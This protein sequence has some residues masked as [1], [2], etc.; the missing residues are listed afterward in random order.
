MARLTIQGEAGSALAALEKLSALIAQANASTSS[1]VAAS[2][3]LKT[4]Y[5][6]AAKAA[7]AFTRSLNDSLRTASLLADEGRQ[8]ASGFSAAAGAIAGTVSGLQTATREARAFRD[9]MIQAARAASVAASA[10]SRGAAS[11][12]TASASVPS[13][14]GFSTGGGAFVFN[15]LDGRVPASQAFAIS[16]SE[17]DAFN[18]RNAGATASASGSTGFLFQPPTARPS[19]AS[20]SPTSLFGGRFSF[21]AG[22][23]VAPRTFVNNL[24]SLT[25][26]GIGQQLGDAGGSAISAIAGGVAK[27]PGL[28]LSGLASIGS[29]IGSFI[30]GTFSKAFDVVFGIVK[31]GLI[32]AVGVAAVAG[33]AALKNA[34]AEQPI[35]EGFGSLS[36]SRGLGDQAAV[37]NE[38]RSAAKGTASDLD[39]MRNANAALLLGAAQNTEQLKF[40]IE[41]GRRLGKVMGRDA[42]EGFN[43]LAVGI[44]RQSRLILDNLGLIV[45]TEDAQDAYAKSVGTTA[46]K[47]GENE[48]RLAFQTAAFEAIRSKM[49]ELGPEELLAVDNIGKLGAAYSNLSTAIA[50]EAI[51]A[52]SEIAGKWAAFIGGFKPGELSE[53]IGGMF[54]YFKTKGSEAL[55]Y[56]FGAKSATRSSLSSFGSALGE[57]ITNPSEAAFEVLGVRF[58]EL[59]EVAGYGFKELW[60]KFKSYAAQALAE[61]SVGLLTLGLAEPDR[62][63]FNAERSGLGKVAENNRDAT[64]QNA[65]RKVAQILEDAAAKK[66]A[67][68]A[69]KALGGVS[70]ASGTANGSSV[71]AGAAN[72]GNALVD[73]AGAEREARDLETEA[74]KKEKEAKEESTKA[75]KALDQA[76][77]ELADSMEKDRRAIEKEVTER[78]R[79][80]ASLTSAKGDLSAAIAGQDKPK[81]FVEL[82]GDLAAHLRSFPV[83]FDKIAT[84]LGAANQAIADNTAKLEQDLDAAAR[85]FLEAT[86][87]RAKSFLLGGEVPGETTRVRALQSAARRQQRRTNRDIF[88][89]ETGSFGFSQI[90]GPGLVPTSGDNQRGGPLSSLPSGLGSA[91]QRIIQDDGSTAIGNLA[92]QITGI[93]SDA[94][95]R[96]R[97]LNVKRA[98]VLARE[99]E[100][101]KAQLEAFDLALE[102]EQEA[103]NQATT[104]SAAVEAQKAKVAGLEKQIDELRR[105]VRKAV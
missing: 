37:L 62:S 17:R 51:P 96:A 70:T 78:E 103:I 72:A 60:D 27:V 82:V 16:Q 68:D 45:R 50:R 22:S 28:L 98:E 79:A 61:V 30:V 41:A 58:D 19:S 52:I 4:E 99:E 42:T 43:D 9:T 80:L 55:D 6:E 23:G 92:E 76:L 81:E 53:S 104:L 85:S 77:D 102:V 8:I 97:E 44:G 59:L 21:G 91:L 46:D 34:I 35:A 100:A 49:A 5:T 13:G 87:R 38:L 75:S 84:E 90:Q 105:A 47:L 69:G 1:L 14:G 32:A 93:V 88:Q 10:S 24:S 67:A 86:D 31:T 57:A 56:V 95:D 94:A 7:G 71:A 20:S 29:S 66:A 40:L 39:L 11:R 63:G 25:G 36:K 2:R 83:E 101:H 18:R 89:Q 73:A 12:S 74:T 33:G 48:K 65:D 15:G 64:R 26:S 54:E 3:T